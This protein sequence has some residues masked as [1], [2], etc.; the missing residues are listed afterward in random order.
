MM[1]S[2]GY[3]ST[4]FRAL[5]RRRGRTGLA[6][7]K[8]MTAST[9]ITASPS[10]T[11]PG[12][13]SSCEGDVHPGCGDVPAPSVVAA[14]AERGPPPRETPHDHLVTE[15]GGRRISAMLRR[16]VR[17]GTDSRR[18][19]TF[20]GTGIGACSAALNPCICSNTADGPSSAGVPERG[21]IQ[22][23]LAGQR[24][25]IGQYGSSDAASL[26]AVAS[27]AVAKVARRAASSV[28]ARSI[29]A[30]R[31]S[32]MSRTTEQGRMPL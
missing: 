23:L 18:P 32:S 24:S 3:L 6:A 1:S 25:M 11:T 17:L 10:S 26:G 28:M 13:R 21:C 19:G 22:L 27:R 16:P 4:S 31:A 5:A 8:L 14:G 2:A 15:G 9:M 20:S 29:S 7:S 12:G 30:R